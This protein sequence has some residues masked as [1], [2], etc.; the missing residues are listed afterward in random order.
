VSLRDPGSYVDQMH[1][2]GLVPGDDQGRFFRG[3]G[4]SQ[5]TAVVAGEVALLLQAKPNLTPDQVKALLRVT[6]D[7]L[8]Q[9]GDPAQGAGVVDIAAAL[10]L[11]STKGFV[12]S[13]SGL[14][15]ATGPTPPAST[16]TGSIEASRGGEHVVDPTSGDP[17]VGERDAQGNPWNGA[18]WAAAS[19]DGDAWAKGGVWNGG[20]W[21][22][23]KWK[24][25]GVLSATWTGSSWNGI[26]W[27]QHDWSDSTFQS[28]SWRNDNWRSR[29]WREDSFKS[30]SWRSLS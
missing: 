5:A 22:T 9:S 12:N 1:P 14:L 20:V 15:T 27:A 25:H 24:D 10:D 7:R 8:P 21:T 23:D 30:R 2:E 13:L 6:A 26:P 28:R 3:S 11:L 16:G 29:S 19:G 18:T 4:T 17:L